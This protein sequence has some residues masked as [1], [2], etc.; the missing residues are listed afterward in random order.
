MKYR[1]HLHHI[2]L[3]IITQCHDADLF[4]NQVNCPSHVSRDISARLDIEREFQPYIFRGRTFQK[5]A[6]P[7]RLYI[8]HICIRNST[9]LC[10]ITDCR[11]YHKWFISPLRWYSH[12]ML[13]VCYIEKSH[14]SM[15]SPY[16]QL[17][18]FSSLEHFTRSHLQFQNTSRSRMTP[19]RVVKHSI[20]KAN[21]DPSS[22][23]S[24]HNIP[25]GWF[26][27]PNNALLSRW[28]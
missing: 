22:F 6:Q 10:E 3:H 26:S 13:T 8:L 16:T 7:S 19:K 2:W 4:T 12:A 21:K 17:I 25:I 18:L 11:C 20:L 9:W 14:T 1:Q 15:N 27:W 5:T 28:N 24:S 23:A